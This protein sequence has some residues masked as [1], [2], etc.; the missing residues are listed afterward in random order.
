MDIDERKRIIEQSRK[1]LADE[2][3]QYTVG[4]VM[5]GEI[6]VKKNSADWNGLILVIPEDKYKELF[7]EG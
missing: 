5:N 7:E 1:E 6:F 3:K 4:S 2:I